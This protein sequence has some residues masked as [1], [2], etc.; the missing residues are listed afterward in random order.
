MLLSNL[1]LTNMRY[2]GNN[3]SLFFLFAKVWFHA[4][5]L[6]NLRRPILASTAYHQ[7]LCLYKETWRS[8]YLHKHK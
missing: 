7:L 8:W 2:I 1:H 6:W 5:F 4:C 3:L